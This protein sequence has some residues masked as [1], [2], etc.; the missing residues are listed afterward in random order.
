MW[1]EL[2]EDAGERNHA[3]SSAEALLAPV[4]ERLWESMV[5]PAHVGV[6]S[7]NMGGSEGPS[8]ERGCC[9][10]KVTRCAEGVV[11]LREPG[12]YPW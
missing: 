4:E 11:W 1:T 8:S 10:E 3:C 5:S 7:A 9:R 2:R 12:A 6:T